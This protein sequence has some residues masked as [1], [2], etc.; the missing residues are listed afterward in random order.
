M[1]VRAAANQ[2]YFN[3]LWS[4]NI[5]KFQVKTPIGLV[6]NEIRIY[7]PFKNEKSKDIK[8]VLES[9]D[10]FRI[11]YASERPL[12]NNSTYVNIR[13]VQAQSVL[14]FSD[15]EYKEYKTGTCDSTMKIVIKVFMEKYN[16]QKI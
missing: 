3:G 10:T 15:K 2:P 9:V 13:A 16:L 12:T 11:G 8:K 7:Y 14:P 4:N 6:H 1:Q 5:S